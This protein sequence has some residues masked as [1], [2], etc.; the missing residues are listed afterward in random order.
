MSQASAHSARIT[1]S[2]VSGHNAESTAEADGPAE[3][4]EF[5]EGIERAELDERAE[6]SD[7][8]DMRDVPTTLRELAWVI[9]R[10]APERAGGPIPTTEVALLKQVLDT[11]GSTVG[12]LA[13]ALGL[14]QPNVSSALRA[15]EGRGMVRRVKNEDD[16]RV[17]QIMPTPVGASEH[18][19]ISEAWKEPLL[20]AIG[21]L[22]TEDREALAAAAG[23]LQR[24]YDQLKPQL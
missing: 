16:R 6:A 14:R 11:P 17:T 13:S 15:L 18:H 8:R 4:A 1:R 19:A 20:D 22:E 10:S 21:T 12:E 7:M 5:G 3:R 9:H 23:A 24:L 2:R